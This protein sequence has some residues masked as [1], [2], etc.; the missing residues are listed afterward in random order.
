M[1]ILVHELSDLAFFPLL[2]REGHP[3]IGR[4][5]V[6]Q[7]TYA[8]TQERPERPVGPGCRDEIDDVQEGID[9]HED[10]EMDVE[11]PDFADTTACTL[12]PFAIVG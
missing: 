5:A 7:E 2:A 9:G 12:V 8:P 3:A 4:E 6:R 11:R 10:S 1:A